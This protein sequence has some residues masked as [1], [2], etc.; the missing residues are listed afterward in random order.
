MRDKQPGCSDRT[1]VVMVVDKLSVTM[2]QLILIGRDRSNV[3]LC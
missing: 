2:I 1:A 3:H